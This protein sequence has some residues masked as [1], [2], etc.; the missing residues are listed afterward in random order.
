MALSV[1][2][3][4][5]PIVGHAGIRPQLLVQKQKGEVNAELEEDWYNLGS[6]LSKV[7]SSHNVQTKEGCYFL[8]KGG[9]DTASLSPEGS[10]ES[11]LQGPQT[12]LLLSLKQ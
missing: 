3:P 11:E 12:H 5:S 7:G 2:H 8:A 6:H 10:G 1:N 4:F 9:R